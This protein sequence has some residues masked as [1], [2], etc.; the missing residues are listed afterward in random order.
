MKIEVKGMHGFIIV[1]YTV[2]NGE[3]ETFELSL[4][5][6]MLEEIKEDTI[7]FIK[8]HE[9]QARTKRIE[10]QAKANEVFK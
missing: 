5:E 10:Q 3:I 4:P 9:S 1:D 2:D 8:D 6:G 7:R